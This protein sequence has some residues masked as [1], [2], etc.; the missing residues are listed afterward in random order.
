MQ[1]CVPGRLVPSSSTQPRAGS[2]L[3]PPQ[4]L[5]GA[6]A[7]LAFEL[8]LDEFQPRVLSARDEQ[9]MVLYSNL[10]RI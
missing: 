7:L 4:K 5:R 10:S 6:E 1:L 8:N 3:H 9:S 2:D